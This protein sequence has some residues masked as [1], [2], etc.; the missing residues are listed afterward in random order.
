[1]ITRLG[2]IGD[3]H[4][5]DKILKKTVDFLIKQELDT[6][7]CTGDIVDGPGD[8]NACCEILHRENIITVSGN[9]ERWFLS[10]EFSNLPDTTDSNDLLPDA[11]NFI[12]SLPKTA[13]VKTSGGTLMLCH[14]LGENDMA[15]LYPFDEGYA[16]EHNYDLQEILSQKKYKYVVGGHTHCKMVRKFRRITIINAG[17]LKHDH[18]PCFLTIDFNINRLQVYNIYFDELTELIYDGETYLLD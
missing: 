18:D 5:E 1:M 2:V 17:T 6:I 4:A 11:F 8:V 15:C 9:H 7:L 13:S 12:K 16:L 14:G 3:I 10:N